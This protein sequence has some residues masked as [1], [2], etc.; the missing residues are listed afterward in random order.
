MSKRTVELQLATP[1]LDAEGRPVRVP[2]GTAPEGTA[3]EPDV[4]GEHMLLNMGPQH[5]VR[6]RMLGAEVDEQVLAAQVRLV[7]DERHAGRLSLRVDARGGE[8]ELDGALAHSESRTLPRSP[9]RS[10]SRMSGGSSSY[11]SAID[12]SSIE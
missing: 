6:R 11:A 2:L 3:V 12:S 1:G 10:R 5:P 4:T 9:R 7:G 8:L